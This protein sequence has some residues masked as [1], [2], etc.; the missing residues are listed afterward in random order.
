MPLNSMFHCRIYFW[1]GLYFWRRYR[2]GVEW[3]GL[4]LLGCG[5]PA[6]LFG[7]FFR[8][9]ADRVGRRRIIL[10]GFLVALTGIERV[11]LRQSR[12]QFCASH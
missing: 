1:L 4:A 3:F 10:S 9:L 12:V 7:P 8:H 2:L 11:K 5:I 6:M